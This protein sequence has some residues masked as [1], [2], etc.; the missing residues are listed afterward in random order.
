MKNLAGEGVKDDART[1]TSA[2][3]G[4]STIQRKRQWWES[5]FR[6]GNDAFNVGCAHCEMLVGFCIE[7]ISKLEPSVD[8][9]MNLLRQKEPTKD[10]KRLW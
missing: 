8:S 4:D 1:L 10:S 6:N 5:G 9:T 7:M 3:G 2:P